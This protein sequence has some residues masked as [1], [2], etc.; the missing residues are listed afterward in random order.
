MNNKVYILAVAT[1]TIASCSSPDKRVETDADTIPTTTVNDSINQDSTAQD[2]V[3]ATG[4]MNGSNNSGVNSS[5]GKPQ[6][7]DTS[8]G[9][10]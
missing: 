10:N 7:V 1:A 8:T 6:K 3:N 4:S 9:K 5:D 2:V